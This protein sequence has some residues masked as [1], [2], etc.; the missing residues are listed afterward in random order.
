MENKLITEINRI[1]TLMG[2]RRNL[3]KESIANPIR[4]SLGFLWDTVLK[5]MSD[6]VSIATFNAKADAY[7]INGVKYNKKEIEELQSLVDDVNNGTVDSTN[8]KDIL[9]GFPKSTQ[10]ILAQ[11]I[12]KSEGS[13]D[14]IYKKFIESIYNVQNSP[15]KTEDQVLNA[16]IKMMNDEDKSID[17]VLDSIFTE[18]DYT[19]K[20]I[21]R[22]KISNNINLKQQGKFAATIPPKISNVAGKILSD[23][24]IATL[25]RIITKDKATVFFDDLFKVL[26]QGSDTTIKNIESLTNGFYQSFQKILKDASNTPETI[27]KKVKELTNAYA[28]SFNREI[29]VLIATSKKDASTILREYN[30][31]EEIIEKL[32]KSEGDYFGAW[33]EIHNGDQR[34]INNFKNTGAKFTNDLKEIVGGRFSSLL[35]WNN[36]VTQFLLTAQ[37]DSWGAWVRRI[38]QMRG[39]SDKK[40]FAEFAFATFFAMNVGIII[41]QAAMSTIVSTWWILEPSVKGVYNIFAPEAYELEISREG[42]NTESVIVNFLTVLIDDFVERMNSVYMEA[43]LG[44]ILNLLPGGL[45]TF[46]NSLVALILS[47]LDRGTIE[48]IEEGIYKICGLETSEVEKIEGEVGLPQEGEQAPQREPDGSPREN[49]TSTQEEFPQDL[50]DVMNDEKENQLIRDGENIYWGNKEYPIKKTSDGVWRVYTN[51]SWYDIN[52]NM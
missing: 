12:K 33:K 45:G 48:G 13:T 28:L 6:Q 47:S 10:Y 35:R 17:E 39:R 22:D 21:L 27:D 50:L 20:Q 26:F 29:N 23:T 36:S 52:E 31:P 1:H 46:Q 41:G 38:V 44:N 24:E 7:F 34:L 19:L 15:F 14:E 4:E 37:F 3:I 18:D 30:I 51:G 16:I 8:F 25:N 5:K 49:E 43:G 2:V 40:T 9:K 11:I 42:E 32:E